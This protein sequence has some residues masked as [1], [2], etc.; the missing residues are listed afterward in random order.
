[1]KVLNR[2]SFF[3][4]SYFCFIFFLIQGF[5]SNAQNIVPDSLSKYSLQALETALLE[6][7]AEGKFQE[8]LPFVSAMLAKAEKELNS[9]DTAFARILYKAADVYEYLGDTEKSL[10][11]LTKAIDIQKVK[12]P[13]HADYATSLHLLGIIYRNLGD[14]EASETA[15]RQALA[16]RKGALGE[17]H[18]RY[19]ATLFNLGLLSFDKGDY[20]AAET[21]Y[22]QALAIRKEVLGEK[23]PEYAAS[24]SNLG[25]LYATRADYTAAE[26]LYQQAL[27]IQ[28]EVQGES[29]PDYAAGLNN[30]ALLYS[31]NGKYILAEKIYLQ[32][33][34]AQKKTFGVEHPDYAAGLDNLGILYSSMSRYAKAED[35]YNR[36]LTIRKKLF[37]TAHPEYAK[38]LNNLGNFYSETAAYND[39]ETFYLKALE[40]KKTALGAE[41]PDYAAAL[42]NLGTLYYKTGN[43]DKAESFY[44]QAAQIEKAVW[45]EE[46]QNY[47]SSLSN[48]GILYHEIKNFEQAEKFYAQALNLQKKILGESHPDYAKLLND[49]ATLYLDMMLYDKAESFY[50]KTADIYRKSLGKEHSKYAQAI[51]NL[52]KLYLLKADYKQAEGFYKEALDIFEKVSGRYH[53]NYIVGLNNLAYLYVKQKAFEPAWKNVLRAVAYNAGLKD[54]SAVSA[55]WAAA[56]QKAEWISFDHGNRS[57]AI[58]FELLS[59]DAAGDAASKKIIV[60]DLAIALLERSKNELST[61]E[62]KLRILAQSNEW[63]LKSMK[64]PAIGKNPEKAFLVSEQDK[65]VLLLDAIGSKQAYISGLLPDSLAALEKELQKE[66]TKA[67]AL[68]AEKRSDAERDSMRNVLTN[69]HLKMAALDKQIQQKYPK[70]AALKYGRQP[71]NASA[72]REM[73]DEGTA[74]IEYLIA[75][76]LVYVF[77]LDKKQLK[78]EECL[79]DKDSFKLQIKALHKVLSDYKGIAKDQDANTYPALAYWFYQK[80]LAPA[81]VHAKGIKSLIV[82]PD[83]ELGHLPFET[84]LTKPAT[85]ASVDY[86][87]LSYL[88]NDFSISYNYSASLWKENKSAPKRKNNRQIFAVAA[89]YENK[90]PAGTMRELRRTSD[91]R[92]REALSP[93]P[94]ARKEVAA[95][96]ELYTGLFAFDSIAVEAI[97]KEKAANYAIIHL[98]M[99]GLLNPKE[100]LLSSLAFTEDRDSAENNF[101]QAYEISKM[102]LNAELVV[103]SACETGIGRFEQGN[104]TA[105][106]ARAFMYAGLPS[107]VVSLWQVN[108]AST[109]AIMQLFYGNLAKGLKKDEALRQAKLEYMRSVDNHMA[110][111]PAFWSPFILLG[112]TDVI[113]IQ[114]KGIATWLWVT[115]VAAVVV[116]LLVLVVF[117]RRKKA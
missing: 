97:F 40:I 10:Q 39:A 91:Q 88:I 45:G 9:S 57:L 6:K 52:G 41:H 78:I 12:I 64:I 33:L 27:A 60:A 90:E 105:S 29:H 15:F 84:F 99:H 82:I 62:D 56:L 17:K 22:K 63:A 103:L 46:H 36:A 30:L 21:Y 77:Y 1:M 20:N 98:A 23:H 74:L 67:K 51:N 71:V 13:K 34:D 11:F 2:S 28:K 76:S 48:L 55:A 44:L 116:L 14:Y 16:L 53:P 100:P 19:A 80:L 73:L 26:Q 89:N 18:P 49:L 117:M 66:L 79:V 101:L 59:L 92:L 68:L 113:N 86:R 58:I 107:L 94:A 70:Y 102:E 54:S 42:S 106:L 81:L 25:N 115:I 47:V 61:E 110:A 96:A 87:K 83:G 108:D 24:L 38:S 31:Q 37:G 109:S 32:A 5:I 112:D 93:L 85:A 111:H 65:S 7:T 95:L 114:Q 69:L 35:A 43:F 4:H 3:E 104:G 72:I 75:D 50:L 8:G